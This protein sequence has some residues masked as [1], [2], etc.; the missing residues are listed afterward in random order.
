MIDEKEKKATAYHE[1]GHAVV[2]FLE[3]DS[4]PLHKVTII[5]RG[6]YGGAT[7]SLPEKDRQSM[8]RKWC[9]AFMRVCFGGRIAEEMFTGDVNSGAYGDIRQ[10][11]GVARKMITEWGMNDRLGFVYYGEDD[12]KPGFF[13]MGGGKE[14]SED[15]QRVIDE[16]VKTLVDR[17][18]DETH[19]ILEA[20]RDK[21]DAVARALIK[22][23][24]LD[25]DDV[26]RIMSGDRITKPT[27]SDLLSQE[28]D[29]AP[30]RGTTIAPSPTNDGP[31]IGLEGGPLPT[32]G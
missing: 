8:S 25:A 3:E 5:P 15:T 22:Y 12:N 32:P 2:Q 14:Y 19:G 13:D 23:E 11:T 1:A 28:K 24:T 29:R 10:A 4:D 16:E 21:I 27:V 26:R 7:M 20:N 6:P 17:L 31:D 9:I 30:Q 18:Y